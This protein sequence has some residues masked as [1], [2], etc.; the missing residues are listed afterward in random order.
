MIDS[1]FTH[2]SL[3]IRLF[4]SL[5]AQLV[6]PVVIGEPSTQTKPVRLGFIRVKP[7]YDPT[8]PITPLKEKQI[9]SCQFGV[10]IERSYNNI[11]FNDDWSLLHSIYLN[12]VDRNNILN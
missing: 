4:G 5:N 2:I 12:K 11:N 1:I 10:I 9:F 7:M 3:L 8:P 6:S